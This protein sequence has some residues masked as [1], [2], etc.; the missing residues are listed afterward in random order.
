MYSVIVV[1]DDAATVELLRTMVDWKRLG[2]ELAG[3]ALSM[4]EGL[5]L[6]QEKQPDLVITDVSFGKR[7]DAEKRDLLRTLYE[8]KYEGAEAGKGTLELSF[9]D[10]QP[11]VII[12]SAC[13]DFEEARRAIRYE[14][15]FYLTK[16]P[17]LEEI[18]EGVLWVLARLE[19]EKKQ[20]K[21]KNLWEIEEN[22]G[23]A[24]REAEHGC[25]AFGKTGEACEG[26]RCPDHPGHPAARAVAEHTLSELKRIRTGTE[27]YSPFIREAI[28]FI[29]SHLDQELSLTVLCEELSL[30]HSYF[31]KKFKR[32]T[33][34]GY[35]TYVT[36]AKMEKARK[37]MEDPRNKAN[38]IARRLGYYDY[39]YF[40]QNFRRYFGCSPRQF[41][42]Q[43]RLP[44]S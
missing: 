37:M 16:P 43:G 7:E 10:K 30:S 40:F 21:R 6:V 39:S 2:C 28:R 41:K 26:E 32:E 19:R 20:R 34:T 38:E 33:G 4:E 17:R 8:R 22:C 36:M 42:S 1:D 24:G 3:T 35:V 27:A 25:P 12:L 31:S 44:E 29:D 5:F 9:L 23:R 18:E 11:S 13:C 15:A 14:A